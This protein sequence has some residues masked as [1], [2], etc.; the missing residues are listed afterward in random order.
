M[1]RRK[2]EDFTLQALGE[3]IERE[4]QI[5]EGQ[6][7]KY[8]ERPEPLL[9]TRAEY[10]DIGEGLKNHYPG[11]KKYEFKAREINCTL[12]LKQCPSSIFVMSLMG[13]RLG[14]NC[15]WCPKFKNALGEP[16]MTRRRKI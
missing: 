8:W 11:L 13:C 9:C 1:I 10:V 7:V 12:T 3:I 2:K 4:D 6:R 16:K 14:S 15:V 5:R